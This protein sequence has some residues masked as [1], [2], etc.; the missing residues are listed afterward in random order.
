MCDPRQRARAP[1]HADALGEAAPSPPTSRSL[2]RSRSWFATATYPTCRSRRYRPSGSSDNGG[3]FRT[4]TPWQRLLNGL[5]GRLIDPTRA[6]QAGAVRPTRPKRAPTSTGQRRGSTAATSTSS[7]RRRARLMSRQSHR[8]RKK[9]GTCPQSP[10]SH[11]QSPRSHPQSAR[12]H[13]PAHAAL[14]RSLATMRSP[15]AH[16]RSLKASPPATRSRIGS[17]PKTSSRRSLAH[18]AAELSN[19][20]GGH[21]RC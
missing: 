4:A 20:P 5:L 14:P 21:V 12:S 9:N 1:A 13:P 11:P 8:H 3:W 17:R 16:M 10:R 2:E 18:A 7:S 19:R 15:S 6:D